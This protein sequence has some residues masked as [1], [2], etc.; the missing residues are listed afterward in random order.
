MSAPKRLFSIGLAKP[1]PEEDLSRFENVDAIK[2]AIMEGMKGVR[3]L[4]YEIE[5]MM[6]NNDDPQAQ[7]ADVKAKLETH[8]D[9]FSEYSVGYDIDFRWDRG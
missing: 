3:E 1:P 6:I 2:A 4:G 8:P 7:Y 9:G 5:V